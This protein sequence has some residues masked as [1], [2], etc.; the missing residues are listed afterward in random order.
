[1][2]SPT[3]I[4][5]KWHK[6]ISVNQ[7]RFA[8]SSALA[9]TAVVPL[10]MARGHR[11]EEVPELPLVVNDSINK[12]ESNSN[13]NKTH[14]TRQAVEIL[15]KLGAFVDVEKSGDSKKIR[16]GSGKARNRRYVQRKGPLIIYS[17]SEG[18]HRAFRNV[19]GVDVANVDNLSLLDLAPG[20]HLGRFCIWTAGAFERLDSIF[21]TYDSEAKEKSGFNLP[22]SQMSNT[23]L[24]RLINSDEVQSIV[25]PAEASATAIPQK[26]N[27]TRTPA[28]KVA[29]NPY[30]KAVQAREKAKKPTSI[31]SKRKEEKKHAKGRKAFYKQ[32][33][34]EGD[35]KF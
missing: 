2:F 31:K 26:R 13:G 25:N 24:A 16:A 27:P 29:L 28:A 33:V 30:H 10:V 19:P 8:V 22:R 23:D 11:I 32:A 17:E 3:K 5:R 6:K 35:V 7:R 18:L 4:W 14:S 1:M 15:K 9:A 34:K 21:G 12:F 20:G